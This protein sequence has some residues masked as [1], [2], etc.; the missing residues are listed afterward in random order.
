MEIKNDFK[1]ERLFFF[2]RLLPELINLRHTRSM[3]IGNPIN[4]LEAKQRKIEQ[5]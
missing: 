3:P 5:N 1:I 2:N 4:V